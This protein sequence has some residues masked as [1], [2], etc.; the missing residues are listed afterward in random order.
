MQDEAAA[1]GLDL[2]LAEF[3]LAV[4]GEPVEKA[5]S[6]RGQSLEWDASSRHKQ[7]AQGLAG[8]GPPTDT[9]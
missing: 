6:S 9:G 7:S 1:R 5:L 2:G 3:T 8:T 4:V